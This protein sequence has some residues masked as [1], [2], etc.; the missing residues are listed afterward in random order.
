MGH[1]YLSKN[2]Q[3]QPRA[4]WHPTPSPK[5]NR[6]QVGRRKS[7]GVLVE[8]HEE[9]GDGEADVLRPRDLRAEEPRGGVPGQ[10]FIN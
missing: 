3:C 7:H 8:D 1:F 4:A 2:D 5:G 10:F 6:R 9:A